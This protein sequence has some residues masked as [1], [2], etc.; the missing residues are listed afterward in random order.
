MGGWTIGILFG[1]EVPADIDL[2]GDD[3][4]GF[5]LLGKCEKAF[6]AQIKAT[7]ASGVL[8][9]FET[10][11]SVFVPDTESSGSTYMMG[12]WVAAGGSGK[13][14]CVNLNSACVQLDEI[15]TTKP[16]MGAIA[17][18]RL[19]WRRFARWAKAEGVTLPEARLYLTPC[20]VA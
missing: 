13:P 19:R 11:E 1:C 7:K 3:G 6:E 15:A 18:A 14:G 8:K 5:G 16:F 17:R 10:A 12:F 2:H 9:R 4:P 20:E